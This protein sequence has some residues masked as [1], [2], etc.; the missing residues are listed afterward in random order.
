M[1]THARSL[2]LPHASSTRHTPTTRSRYARIRV[3]DTGVLTP[4]FRSHQHQPLVSI[5]LTP[6]PQPRVPTPIP[7]RSPHPGNDD[8]LAAHLTIDDEQEKQNS[9]SFIVILE[10]LY[11]GVLPATLLPTVTFLI[12]I[13]L[14]AVLSV[15]YMIAHFE[16]FVRQTRGDLNTGMSRKHKER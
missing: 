3:V 10:P 2:S 12:P 7:S 9:V 5:P 8:A 4:G 6:Q 11:L 1:E 16:P 15:P 13:V 14:A